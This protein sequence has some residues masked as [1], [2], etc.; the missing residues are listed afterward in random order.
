MNPAT[1]GFG[2]AC[3]F[4]LLALLALCA[5]ARAQTDPLP[6]W[7]EGAA[8]QAIVRFVRDTTTQGSPQFVDPVAR[9][10]TFDQDGTTWV[11]QPLYAQVMFAF[12]QVGVLAGKEP[13][14]REIEPFRTILSGDPA[15]I[16]KLSLPELE[17]VLAET[18][19][20]MTVEVFQKSVQDWVTTAQHPRFHRL[21]TELVYQPMIEVMQYLRANG[22][23]TYIV[24]GGGQ[25]F[26]RVYSERVYGVPREQVV[27]ST[28]DTTFGYD[29][30]G[31]SQLTKVP[32][33]VRVD[34]KSGKPVGIHLMIGRRP[35]AA[36]GNS[37]GDQ[38]MLEYAQD[39]GGARLMMLV[40]HDDATREYAY[41]PDSKIGTFPDALMSEAKQRGWVVI[42]MKNDWKRIFAWEP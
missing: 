23:K 32:Q 21:Y 41:G 13:K 10:A 20:G 37:S 5:Q 26:V 16:A 8:K 24:T 42:S 9:I 33:G 25:D 34:D 1:A 2:S 15:Q 6:S 38:E 4:A 18:H 11:E 29:A 36:F 12:H 35:T 19:T 3:R 39:G 28:S 30:D 17:K 22:Y 31:K 7:N 14:L 40:H 27:G